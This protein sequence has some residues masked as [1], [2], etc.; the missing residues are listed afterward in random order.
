MGCA[1]NVEAKSQAKTGP[2]A[3]VLTERLRLD[4]KS[5]AHHRWPVRRV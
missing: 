5:I 2:N 4:S 3:I 1:G